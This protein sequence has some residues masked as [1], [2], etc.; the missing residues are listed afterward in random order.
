MKLKKLS[1]L[2]TA[3][4]FV[5]TNA[6]SLCQIT[7]SASYN[8]LNTCSNT[9]ITV[10]GSAIL[11][12]QDTEGQYVACGG[13]VK[14]ELQKLIGSTWI[15]QTFVNTSTGAYS[16][17]ILASY[18]DGLYRIYISNPS[19]SCS[20]SS[21]TTPWVS[22]GGGTNLTFNAYSHSN[23]YSFNGVATFNTGCSNFLFCQGQAISM[24][25]IV[26]TNQSSNSNANTWSVG[27]STDAI[28]FSWTSSIGVPPS[29]YNLL[30]LLQTNYGNPVPPGTYQIALKTYNGCGY[31]TSNACLTILDVPTFLVGQK[32]DATNYTTISNT[33]GCTTPFSNVCPAFPYAAILTAENST[34][35]S[36]EVT[37]G[38]WSCQLEEYPT[39][40]AA[41]PTLVFTK[42][43]TTIGSM[44]TLNNMDLNTYATTYG[45]KPSNYVSTN[46]YTKRW[47]FTLTIEYDCGNVYTFVCW[48]KYTLGGCRLIHNEQTSSENTAN[49]LNE[50]VLS[51]Y[52]NPT[53]SKLEITTNE[54]INSAVLF[55]VTGKEIKVDVENNTVN[56]TELKAGVY[57]LKIVTPNG[58]AIRK[59]M[60]QD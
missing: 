60:K 30:S 25:N 17:S 39:N 57:T 41:T 56:L 58:T 40:C 35:P 9:T 36:N 32:Y 1:W 6:F 13:V 27:T 51:V 19:S 43:S 49:N 23:S 20:C 3:L 47:K 34:L 55:D 16:I 59:I 54:T 38:T 52:P 21:S 14:V 26:M 28:N 7:G 37:N 50:S 53:S 5:A 11:K 2:F 10:H 4:L 12:K 8:T 33:T 31:T 15:T 42:P 24:D 18:G 29:S 22:S 46:A 44:S 48:L 45:G